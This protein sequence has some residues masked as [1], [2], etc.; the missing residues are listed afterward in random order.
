MRKHHSNITD[1]LFDLGNVL[2]PFDWGK[3]FSRLLPMLPQ[4]FGKLLSEDEETFKD[5]F[6]QHVLAMEIGEI[7]FED[8]QMRM[9]S[10]LGVDLTF[11]SF[12]RIW[13]DIFWMDDEMVS[14][15]EF[16]SS[17]YCTWLLSNT[18]K[19]HYEWIIQHFPRVTFFRGAALSFDLGVMKPSLA[20]YEKAIK[21]FGID[22]SCAVF[23]DDLRENVEGAISAGM[24]G[25][26]YTGRAQLIQDL[27]SLG[28]NFL[29]DLE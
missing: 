29:N 3:A 23:I 25:V 2:V 5:L 14:L 9:S 6:H 22:P 21:M 10:I 11:D 7:D 8:F 4:R 24:N 28:V 27:R 19:A 1:I 16:L 18:C 26:V 20:F 13:C 17:H 12:R 15:G